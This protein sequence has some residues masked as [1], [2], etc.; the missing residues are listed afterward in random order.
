MN[1]LTIS[2]AIQILDP[3][4]TA[5]AIRE[6]E[7]YGGFAGTEIA[8]KTVDQA[9]EMACSMMRAYRKDMHMLYKITRITHTGTYGK[10]GGISGEKRRYRW[11]PFPGTE[12]AVERRSFAGWYGCSGRRKEDGNL[13]CAYGWQK[14]TVP[15][16]EKVVRI[17]RMYRTDVKMRREPEHIWQI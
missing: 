10:R 3:K 14:G 4:T 7:Y 17:V 16:E 1:N 5:D 9:C 8:I 13:K 12:E 11:N 15:E 6:I 2:D